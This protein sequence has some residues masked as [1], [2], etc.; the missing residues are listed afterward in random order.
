[1]KNHPHQSDW[2]KYDNKE[3]EPAREIV[4]SEKLETI[5]PKKRGRKPKPKDV[6]FHAD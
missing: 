2:Y 4:S 6:D 1:M 3:Q 5:S